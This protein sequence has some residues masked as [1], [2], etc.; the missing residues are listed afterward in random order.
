[1][2]IAEGQAASWG[3]CCQVFERYL[4]HAVHLRALVVLN[5][6]YTCL[7]CCTGAHHILCIT[8]PICGNSGGQAVHS[9]RMSV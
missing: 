7:L 6:H 8:Q 1:M 3:C 2:P 9:L 4:A 5:D